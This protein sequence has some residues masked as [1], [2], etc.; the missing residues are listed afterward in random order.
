VTRAIKVVE[1]AGGAVRGDEI[2]VPM[3]AP[4]PPKLEQW[5]MGIPVKRVD[6]LDPN[7]T[8]KGKWSE[9]YWDT[10]GL[11]GPE[12]KQYSRSRNHPDF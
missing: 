10:D 11:P 4:K 2:I 1:K 6:P 3:Q 7:W 5:D 12:D 8:W 9:H